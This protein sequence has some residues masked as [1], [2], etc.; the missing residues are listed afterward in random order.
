M[1]AI[2][3]NCANIGPMLSLQEP[4]GLPLHQGRRN[5]CM[6][7]FIITAQSTLNL[8]ADL[9]SK[10]SYRYLLTYK[11]SQDQVEMFFSRIRQQS[12]WN[13]NP[14]S[15][16][17]RSSLKS[18]IMSSTITPSRHGNAIPH[19]LLRVNFYSAK[20]LAVSNCLQKVWSTFCRQAKRHF[21]S[22]CSV[23]H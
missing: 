11:F 7:G 8:V 10:E 18:L 1:A 5:Q 20:I 19:V 6:L 13:N 9:L 2:P 14:T 22:S 23:L 15:E 4:S 12:G 3:S 17:F 21:A 16:Q